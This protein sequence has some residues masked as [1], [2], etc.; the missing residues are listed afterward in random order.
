[1]TIPCEPHCIE[2]TCCNIIR[3]L[4]CGETLHI[5]RHD[6]DGGYTMRHGENP[7]HVSPLYPGATMFLTGTLEWRTSVH[8]RLARG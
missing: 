2:I 7:E 6:L 3:A 4:L 1:M 5:L 8:E